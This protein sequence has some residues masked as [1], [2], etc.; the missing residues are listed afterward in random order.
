MSEF[1]LGVKTVLSRTGWYARQLAA[2][3]FPGVAVLCYHGVRADGAVP[4]GLVLP[5]LHLPESTFAEHC[6]VLRDACHPISLEQW[7]AARA[8]RASLP[9]NAVL[10]T[11][12]DGYRSVV[13]RALPQLTALSIPCIVFLATDSIQRRSLF[14]YDALARASEPIEAVKVLP[15]EEWHARISAVQAVAEPGD[16][17]E[18]MTIED[19]QALAGNPLVTIGSHTA[20]HLIL[21][22]ADIAVQEHDIRASL[23]T[24]DHWIGERPRAFAYPNGRPGIDYTADTVRLLA[25]AGIVAAFTT[26][27]GFARLDESP[28]ERPRLLVMDEV[29]GVELL[30]RLTKTWPR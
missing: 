13:T 1:A 3:P 20:S 15:H 14:W 30:H 9:P 24:L 22:Q 18:P 29:R 19:V 4:P 6:R 23:D 2:D 12:D 25:D 16:P 21:A 27:H 11:F 17:L 8:G 5:S 7:E 26:G 28:L 10:V